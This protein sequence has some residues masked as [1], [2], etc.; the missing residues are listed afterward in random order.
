MNIG[1]FFESNTNVDYRIDHRFVDY[2]RENFDFDIYGE[3]V[4]SDECLDSILNEMEVQNVAYLG[5]D[6]YWH[7][8]EGVQEIVF[9]EA[10]EKRDADVFYFEDGSSVHI[11]YD[12]KNT[13]IY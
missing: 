3:A 4:M 11:R 2:I 12:A 7:L 10:Y 13:R 9:D 5:D 1:E 6:D 8:Y